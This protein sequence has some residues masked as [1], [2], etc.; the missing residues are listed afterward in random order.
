MCRTSCL[1]YLNNR[2]II[3]VAAYVYNDLYQKLEIR[4]VADIEQKQDDI[5]LATGRR[6]RG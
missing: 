6:G 4:I 1:V 5:A 2:L 3:Q